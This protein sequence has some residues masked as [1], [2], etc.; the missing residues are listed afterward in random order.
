[1]SS[2]QQYCI[3]FVNQSASA[4]KVCVYQD[5]SNVTFSQTNCKVLAWMLT[6]ANSL[7]QVKLQWRADYDFVWFDYSSPE[8]RQVLP[9]N[10]NTGNSVAFK[11]N[12]YGYYFQTM[13]ANGPA[14]QL[15]IQSDG[16]IPTVNKTLVGIGMNGAGT[17]AAPAGPNLNYRFTPVKDASLVYWISFGYY[18]FEVN[19]PIDTATLNTP[20]Q[21]IF[22]YGVYTMTA[23]LNSQNQWSIYS[24]P[25]IGAETNEISPIITYEAGKG[26]LA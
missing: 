18:S 5:N 2:N 21:I 11:K 4:G 6:G 1:M 10:V 9:T 8:T 20:A 24:G 26:I 12:Q 16:S 13:A 19:D 23:V 22:P 3:W 7:V 14:G 25:P 15:S 17:F